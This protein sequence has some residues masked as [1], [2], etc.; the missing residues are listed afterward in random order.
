MTNSVTKN[1]NKL[2]IISHALVIPSFRLRW[3]RFARESD[4]EVHLLVPKYWEQT[5]FGEKV[6]Y[7]TQNETVDNY[8]VHAVETT[9]VSVW[10]RYFIKGLGD[11]LR[12]IQPDVIYLI[13]EEGVLIHH[14]LYW[15]R[16]I[17]SR[18]SKVLFFTMNAR[19]VPWSNAP[20]LKKTIGKLMWWQIKK[21]TDGALAHYP[22]CLASLR[23]GGYK[24][25]VYLQ[26]QV[27]VDE[28]LFSPNEHARCHIRE[29]L[30]ISDKFVF[31]YCG[32]MTVDK[33]VDDLVAAFKRLAQK[34]EN[35]LYLLLVGNGP[36]KESIELDLKQSGLEGSVCVTGFIA[37]A[38][39]PDYM[40]AMDAFVLASKTMPHWIDTFPLV[41]VQS[42]SVGLPVIASDSASLPWQLGDTARLYHEGDRDQLYS[43]MDDIYTDDEL[44]KKLSISGQARSHSYFCHKGMTSAFENILQQTCSGDIK[45]HQNNEPYTQWKAYE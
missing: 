6:I 9:N 20:W 25:P 10:G 23:Q 40:N 3:E 32:R 24:K 22:G 26:T 14:Q 18:K 34:Y 43:S 2:L 30:A 33:G 41:T 8:H 4:W 35:K 1:T 16:F 21:C 28:G 13:H 15:E 11:K 5:W 19:G 42:Q 39:I 29:R 38:E 45:F 37:Q 12:T 31:G 7:E 44:R 17:Q 27:G 36:L